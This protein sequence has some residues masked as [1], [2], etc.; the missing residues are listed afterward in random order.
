MIP[1]LGRSP[2]EG[3]G[4]PIQYPGLENSMDC[5]VL[6]DTKSRTQ[7]SDFDFHMLMVIQII[8]KFWLLQMTATSSICFQESVF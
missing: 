7:K 3:K 1:G 5:I 4:H 8:S 2:G 6:G